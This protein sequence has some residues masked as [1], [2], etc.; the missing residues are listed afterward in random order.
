MARVGVV[1]GAAILLTFCRGWMLAVSDQQ[2][3]L[4]APLNY[5]VVLMA[6]LCALYSLSQ[7]GD[8]R[9]M[10]LFWPVA[11]LMVWVFWCLVFFTPVRYWP[12]RSPVISILLAVVIASQISRAELR[13]LRHCILLLAGLF[14]LVVLVWNPGLLGA[15][16]SGSAKQRLGVDI[17]P[18]NVLFMPRVYYTLV[19]TC[20][21]TVVIER[22]LWL[23]SVAIV[24]II[25]PAL[26][27]L[28]SG[29]R[30]PLAALL[31]AVLVFLWGALRNARG[32]GTLSLL[33]LGTVFALLGLKA[34]MSLFPT[35]V[36][37]VGEDDTLRISAYGQI[38]E[39]VVRNVSLIG[40]GKGDVY[41]HNIF[42]EFLQDYGVLGVVLFLVF[43]GTNLRAMWR[44]YDSTRDIE[45][46]W[47][48]G[49]ILIQLVAQQFSLDIYWGS[50]WAAL[51]LP[52]GVRWWHERMACEPVLRRPTQRRGLAA[53]Q[54]HRIKAPHQ[55]S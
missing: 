7:Y 47:A 16:V 26:M 31:L 39:N 3:P 14:S 42:L 45:V 52:I 12:E 8:W 10:K 37:R 51:M 27:G 50:L 43:L 19:F 29:S 36:R 55:P 40:Q 4:D 54:M 17:S 25:I 32:M 28:S 23:R 6:P 5:F 20:F 1:F 53:P 34:V 13:L 48:F 18:A 30:G 22:R 11:M 21:A 35:I 44:V 33:T 46:V 24:L 2:T 15:A 49:L 9:L 41:A 38:L